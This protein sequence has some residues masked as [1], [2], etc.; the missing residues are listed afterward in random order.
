MRGVAYGVGNPR[1]RAGTSRLFLSRHDER[2]D[3]VDNGA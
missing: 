2:Q 3:D 1:T